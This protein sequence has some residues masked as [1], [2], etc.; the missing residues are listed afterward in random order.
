[1]PNGLE[2]VGSGLLL[3]PT[4]SG[5]LF[6]ATDSSQDFEEITDCE[7][8]QNPCVKPPTKVA[9]PTSVRSVAV[10][11]FYRTANPK[12][13]VM[14]TLLVRK[15]LSGLQPFQYHI[16]QLV[17]H[18]RA[19]RKI[20]RVVRAHLRWQA[21]FIRNMTSLWSRQERGQQIRTRRCRNGTSPSRTGPVLLWTF[22]EG[23][24][25]PQKGKEAVVRH[26]LM[27][28]RSRFAEDYRRL[29]GF[30]SPNQMS[31]SLSVE[32]QGVL[33]QAV[34]QLENSFD[35]VQDVDAGM[36]HQ[37]ILHALEEQ[38]NH[39][40]QQREV[41]RKWCERD[42]HSYISDPDAFFRVP[43]TSKSEWL[44]I[45]D[46]ALPA[47]PQEP[48]PEARDFE[49]SPSCARLM[50]DTDRYVQMA[51]QNIQN[52]QPISTNDLSLRRRRV[53][54]GV[55]GLRRTSTRSPAI[56]LAPVLVAASI[57]RRAAS[58]SPSPVPMSPGRPF[59]QLSD[60]PARDR[61]TPR[62]PAPL[63]SSSPLLPSRGSHFA[64]V[65]FDLSDSSVQ[66]PSRSP[67]QRASLDFQHRCD[68]NL[69]DFDE[70]VAPSPGVLRHR[71]SRDG[72]SP[73]FSQPAITT[74]TRSASHCLLSLAGAEGRLSPQ[75]N[76]TNSPRVSGDGPRYRVSPLPLAP[77]SR[78]R[79]Q[80]SPIEKPR[81]P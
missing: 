31:L 75:P 44:G 5:D 12:L 42:F 28:Q 52:G 24:T 49:L 11:Q 79:R 8:E 2:S 37:R 68:S 63:A 43:P 6:D 56:S 19:A 45:I 38:Q 25:I 53:S 58:R 15:Y 23:R 60:S 74:R 69:T 17:L 32:E 21:R 1:M 36:V 29:T 41:V 33:S 81:A 16:R 46:Q 4:F 80:L 76:G 77:V 20:Q 3:P 7:D 72:I 54:S 70:P 51:R 35:S 9:E 30:A 64:P 57:A 13:V 26:L 47:Q 59:G 22:F 67:I 66:Q 62:S 55:S 50:G 61:P 14:A 73:T 40:Q 78:V 34:A 39:Q 65:C 71:R 48:P 27:L 10:L 18:H